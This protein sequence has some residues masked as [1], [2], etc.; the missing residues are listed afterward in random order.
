M[1]DQDLEQRIRDHAYRIWV[2]E[3]RP[4]GRA[5]AH[6][7]MARELVAIEDNQ[8]RATKSNPATAD[9]DRAVTGTQPVEPIEAVEN[10]GKF[11]TLTDQGEEQA[12]PA[13]RR[14]RRA[15]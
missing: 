6:W 13:R 8:G 12:Y 15:R 14:R 3:G 7:D 9:R 10:Q 5:S 1:T 4:A 11:P 2:S